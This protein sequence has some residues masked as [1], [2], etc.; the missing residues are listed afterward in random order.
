[1]TSLGS[2]VSGRCDHHN[3][4][5]DCVLSSLVYNTLRTRNILISTQRY[6]EHA[7]VVALTISDYPLNALCD[8]FFSYATTFTCFHQHEFRFMGPP[9]IRA[10]TE[11]SITGGGNRGLCTVPLPRLYWL[12]RKQT[13]PLSG[14]ILVSDNTVSRC[15]EIRMRTESRIEKSDRYAFSRIVRICI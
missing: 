1:M 8:V 6:I 2:R 7:D 14:Q 3:S 12:S 15:Y 13:A 4:L 11:L 9:A 10:I 5:T